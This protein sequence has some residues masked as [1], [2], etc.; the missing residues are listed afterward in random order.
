[1]VKPLQKDV[2]QAAFGHIVNLI[3]VTVV[4]G[5]T[6]FLYRHQYHFLLGLSKGQHQ[7]Y[8]VML[9]I[10]SQEPSNL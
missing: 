7:V 10:K 9:R 1:M 4:C 8:A 2:L 5:G 3:P 6:V